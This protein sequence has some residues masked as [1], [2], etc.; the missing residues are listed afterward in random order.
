MLIFGREDFFANLREGRIF[1]C[2][3]KIKEMDSRATPAIHF[4]YYFFL[5]LE[6]TE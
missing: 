3:A 2:G 6:V 1:F 5:P 4:F